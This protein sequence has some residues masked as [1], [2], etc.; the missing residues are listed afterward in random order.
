MLSVVLF[1]GAFAVLRDDSLRGPVV[2]SADS[3]ALTSFE[4]GMLDRIDGSTA[5]TYDEAIEDISISHLAFRS[6]GSS[7]ANETAVWIKEKFDGFGIEAWTEPFK[8]TTWDLLSRPELIINVDG[9]NATDNDRITLGSFQSEHFSWPTPDGGSS[10]DAVILPLPATSGRASIGGA[11]VDDEAWDDVNTR[12]KVVFVGRELR[13]NGDWE[14]KLFQKMAAETPVAVVSI[15]WYDWMS[16][17]PPA[18]YPSTGGRP[19]GVMADYYWNLRIPTGSIN[20]T[21]SMWIKGALSEQ[22]ASAFVSIPSSIASGNHYNVVGRL[23]GQ[24]VPDKM[25]LVSG[26]YDMVMDAGFCDNGAGVAG[27]MEL[28]NVTAEAVREGLYEPKCTLLFVAF[29]AEELGMVGSIN[30][31]RTHM[32]EVQ[33]V[34]AA[35]NLD[36]IGSDELKVSM[37]ESFDDLDLDQIVLEAAEDLG[38]AASLEGPGGSDQESFRDPFGSEGAYYHN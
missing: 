21:E 37:T 8:F 13:W 4:T 25:I 23:P 33:N 9:N 30:F 32:A 3:D 14:Q 19:L 16:G 36:C 2:A 31:V 27:V 38:V 28:A 17:F 1:T 15:W 11:V 34:V 24:E 35:L 5:W 12:G 20:F 26:H 22:N 7:G 29:V 10:V 6:A 18:F